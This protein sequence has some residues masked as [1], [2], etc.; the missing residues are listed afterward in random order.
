LTPIVQLK[1][2]EPTFTETPYIPLSAT[3]TATALVPTPFAGADLIAFSSDRTGLMQ[4]WTMK[5]DGTDQRQLTNMSFGVCQ[6]AWSPNGKKM[7]FISPCSRKENLEY[8]DARIYTMNSDGTEVKVLPVSGT[9]DFDPAWSPDSNRLAFTSLR[10]G[11]AHIFVYHFDDQSLHEVSD[12]RYSDYQPAWSPDGKH[13]AFVRQK[14]FHHIWVMSDQGTTLYQLTSNG[15]VIDLWPNWAPDGQYVIFSRSQ[16]DPV[17]PWLMKV[18]IEDQNSAR[19]V[20][21]LPED[22]ADNTAPIV[23]AVISPDGNWIMYESWP[24]GHNH[25]IY[26]IDKDGKNRIRLTTDPGFDF[27]PAWKPHTQ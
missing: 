17:I 10:T 15:Q 3:A 13:I 6:P 8:P 2:P 18:R 12:T 26:I 23:R 22:K 24:D 27:S 9:G 25:D 20:R 5:T 4:I 14:P 16:I 21:V 19:E 7:A 1:S 11:T